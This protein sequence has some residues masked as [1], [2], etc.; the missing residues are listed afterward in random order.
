M[1]LGFRILVTDDM[2][3]GSLGAARSKAATATEYLIDT[4][5]YITLTK[6]S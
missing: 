4:I 6:A 2:G 3:S 5:G 1:K